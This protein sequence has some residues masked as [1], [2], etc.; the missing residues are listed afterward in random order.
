MRRRDFLA[1]LGGAA[2][3]WPRASNAQ[4]QGKVYRVGTLS[5]GAAMVDKSPNGA[6][7][8]RGLAQLGYRQGSNIAF[9][10][11]GAEGHV[12]RLPRLVDELVAS[13]VDVIVT[14]GYPATLAAKQ[15]TTLPVVTIF[16]GDP[17]GTRLVD[18]LARPGGNL[19]G[20]SDVS[21]ELTPKRMELLKEMAPGLRR[22]AMLWNSDDLGMTLRY[23]A[24]EAGAKA[25]GI[26]V[27]ALGVREPDDFNL[28]FAALD[29]EMPD[30]ILMVTDSLTILNRQRVFE[31][32]ATHRLPAI[33]EFD[34][35]VRDGGLM[36]YGPELDESFGRVAALVDRILKGTKPAELP[37]E[38]PTRFKF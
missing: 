34:F 19:T 17:V 24:S 2:L 26:S 22:V 3:A 38:Q 21:G 12:D 5:A 23:R 1:F 33:Y 4:S 31:F 36:S 28:A 27:Q 18:S 9:E 37:F 15:G 13:K 29:R 7:L 6:A 8:I 30:A 14:S 20:I 16:A 32:A 11:R 35:L 10:L 25:M